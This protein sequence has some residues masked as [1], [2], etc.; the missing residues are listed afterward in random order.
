LRREEDAPHA[1][2]RGGPWPTLFFFFFFFFYLHCFFFLLMPPP[3]PPIRPPP[4][5]VSPQAIPRFSPSDSLL[6]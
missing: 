1:H 2:V 6:L 5:T 3:F 4:P